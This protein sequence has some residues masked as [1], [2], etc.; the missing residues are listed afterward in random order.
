MTPF[1][2]ITALRFSVRAAIE[3]ALPPGSPSQIV[4]PAHGSSSAVIPPIND[5]GNLELYTITP[6]SLTRNRKS[7][8]AGRPRG[9]ESCAHL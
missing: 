6:Y 1:I 2:A 7:P 4:L 9:Q 5:D 3:G 8:K